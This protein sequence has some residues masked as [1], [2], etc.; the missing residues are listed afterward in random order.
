MMQRRNCARTGASGV[1]RTRLELRDCGGRD[2]CLFGSSMQ[3]PLPR[4]RDPIGLCLAIAAT[5]ALL[6]GW[7]LGIPTKLY[8][9]EIH[10]VPAARKLLL[11]QRANVEH[12]LLAKEAIAAAIR[13][14][15][16]RPWAWRLPSLLCGTIGLFAFGRALWWAS[17][18]RFA[19]LAGMVL[20]ATDFAWLIQSRIAMLDMVMAGLAMVALWQVAAA[21][22]VANRGQVRNARARLALASVCIGL[23]M[24]AKWSVVPAFALLGI[25]MVATRVMAGGRLALESRDLPPV[26]GIALMELVFWLGSLPLLVYWASFWPAMYYRTEPLDPLRIV[27]WHRQMLALQDS[28]VTKHPY[29]SV[30]YQWAANWRAIWY[31]Y[32]PVDGAQRGVVLVGNPLTMLA[33]LP[34]LGYCLWA[35]IRHRRWDAGAL[36]GFYTVSLGMWAVSGKPVQFYYHYLLPGTFLMGALA[37]ALDALWRVPS[38]A[39]WTAPLVLAASCAL[40]AWFYPIIAAMPL[41]HGIRSFE[42]WMWLKSWR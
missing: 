10:Y 11:L 27:D 28:V 42:K 5:F 30:W 24:A 7:R 36:V 25:G 16:D 8:F 33:G 20:L 15:G 9:D 26:R 21:I 37:L 41:H 14:L 13:L 17:G 38:P 2:G 12:P 29:Q 23:S 40:L 6:A 18:R 39:R 19:A 32:E 4:E 35:A 31:L 34:T 3:R 1:G 22:G